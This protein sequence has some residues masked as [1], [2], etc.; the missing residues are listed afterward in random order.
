MRTTLPLLI[1]FFIGLFMVG[2]FFIPHWR[3]Q[4][5][6]VSLL[7]WG[8]ILAA[9]AFLLGLINL[10]QVNLPK[11]LNRD[12]DWGYKLIMLLSL[13][14]TVI[15]GF[16]GGTDRLNP[17]E[18]FS[19]IFQFVFT[20]LSA[21]MFSL[22][23]FYIASAAFRA[24]RARNLDATILLSAACLVMIARVP[25]GEGLGIWSSNTLA[26]VLG[27]WTQTVLPENYLTQFMNWLMDVPNIAA[28]RAIFV[29]AALGAVATGLRIILGIERSHLGSD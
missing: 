19:W 17:G 16:M 1:S 14:A 29:G 21:T 13:L 18:P 24:F 4:I 3:Y 9:G 10:L 23:A 8:V 22:L 20:P 11:V 6:K 5:I 25:I 28:R 7:E 15:A 27:D 26:A 2:E 12:R